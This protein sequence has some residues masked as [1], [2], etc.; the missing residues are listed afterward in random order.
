MIAVEDDGQRMT[1]EEIVANILLLLV[2]G[3]EA[4]ANMIGNALIALHRH[5][6]QLQFAKSDLAMLPQAVSECIRYDSSI[7]STMRVALDDMEVEGVHVERGSTIDV[8]IG[9]AN[10]DSGKFAEP[11]VLRI[12]RPVE[13][14]SVLSF[15]GGLHS[16]LGARL[17]SMEIE[18][19][20]AAIF[21]RFPSM[22]ITNLARL[23]WRWR[24]GLRGVESLQAVLI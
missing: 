8:C 17:A 1:D 3:Q 22:S 21:T 2:A 18:A 11:D 7:Q 9:A 15:G 24:S 6:D 16:C 13:D 12:D 10:R 23:R 5:P 19:A 14:G 20:L 4:T